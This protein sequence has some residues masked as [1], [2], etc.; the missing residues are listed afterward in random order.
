[1]VRAV[2]AD[3][4]LLGRQLVTLPAGALHAE[5]RLA[6]PTELRNQ[7]IEMTIEGEASAGSA[8]LL[9]ERWRRRPVGIVA[10]HA[11]RRRDSRS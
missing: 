11:S 4:R 3:G 8:L 1:M 2:A 6:M 5:A 9:D 7:A 10:A